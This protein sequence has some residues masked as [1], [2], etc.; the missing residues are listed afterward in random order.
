MKKVTV[1][2]LA[3][4]ALAVASFTSQAAG[5]GQAGRV[6]LNTR[7]VAATHADDALFGKGTI[8]LNLGVGLGNRYYSS[9]DNSLPFVGMVEYGLT[10]LGPG[11]LGIGLYGG[12]QS[13][14]VTAGSYEAKST[15]LLIQPRAMYHYPVSESFEVYGGAG[16]GFY[17]GTAESVTPIGKISS[18]VNGTD[19]SVMA[20]GRFFFAPSIGAFAEV[21]TND[22]SYLKAGLSLKF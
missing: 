17:R 5:F 15:A 18:D 9:G 13:N 19:F 12:Y 2:L 11:V 14:K 8:G 10:E 4:A 20:G 3:L 1:S 7:R 22:Y 21:A 16:L 6:G